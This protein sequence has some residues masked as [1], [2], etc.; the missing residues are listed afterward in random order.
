MWVRVGVVWVEKSQTLIKNT[1]LFIRLQITNNFFTPSLQTLTQSLK[2][3]QSSPPP[4][5][6]IS[7]PLSLC[8]VL[9]LVEQLFLSHLF[10]SLLCSI[11]GPLP[12]FGFFFS[13]CPLPI[14]LN[15]P[16][17]HFISELWPFIITVPIKNPSFTDLKPTPVV[18]FACLC[19]VAMFLHSEAENMEDLF[20]VINTA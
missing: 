17:L 10:F 8:R 7:P 15:H 19:L 6:F 1:E 9:S 2:T 4:L 18:S 13:L 14:V 12:L 3:P 16:V 5:L 20:A 11:S